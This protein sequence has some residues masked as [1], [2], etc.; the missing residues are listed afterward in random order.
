ML[1]PYLAK[2]QYLD[3][4]KNSQHSTI[5]NKQKKLI[6]L[7]NG[8][9]LDIGT[10]CKCVVIGRVL[11]RAVSFNNHCNHVTELFRYH[12]NILCAIPLY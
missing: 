9:K 4:I 7:K 3:Y 12:K 11:T 1:T 6:W 5:K 8:Q 10:M 2:D